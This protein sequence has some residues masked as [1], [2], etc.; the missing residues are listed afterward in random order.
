[1][2]TNP[3]LLASIAVS[4]LLPFTAS[5]AQ[6]CT[7][8]PTGSYV[9]VSTTINLFPQGGSQLFRRLGCS[10]SYTVYTYDDLELQ[11]TP[12]DPGHLPGEAFLFHLG[13]I[14]GNTTY[15]FPQPTHSPILPLNLCP[16]INMVCCQSNIPAT[17]EDIVGLPP[18][19]GTR[20]LR[21]K[22]GA[23][24]PYPIPS[25]AYLTY[26]Y[27]GTGWSPTTPIAAA[28]E[29]VII[30]LGPFFQNEAIVVDGKM[31]FDVYSPA[32][33]T[34]TIESTD[35]LTAPQWQILTTFSAGS[36]DATHITDP[37]PINAHA[38]RYYRARLLLPNP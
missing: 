2:K 22:R 8:A 12:S 36:G 24:N 23:T 27:L 14:S 6:F 38:Q 13:G 20:L 4:L 19:I 21:L 3:I 5:A 35:S 18:V 11:W 17:Y 7:N 16:G 9:I 31:E 34:T 30:L 1:M 15:C 25:D 28:G 10:G 32:G 26:T 37:D 29:A 33:Y